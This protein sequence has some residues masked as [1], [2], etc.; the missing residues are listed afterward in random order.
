LLSVE[1]E[2]VTYLLRWLLSLWFLESEGTRHVTLW[3]P[4]QSSYIKEMTA[5]CQLILTL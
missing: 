5:K 3:Y 4:T 1:V 2:V